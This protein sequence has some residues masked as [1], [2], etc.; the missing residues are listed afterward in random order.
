MIPLQEV[1]VM[2]ALEVLFSQLAGQ[3]LARALGNNRFLD[4]NLLILLCLISIRCIIVCVRIIF[5]RIVGVV[6]L[7]DFCG[8]FMDEVM[9]LVLVVVVVFVMVSV[10]VTPMVVS[11]MALPVLLVVVIVMLLMVH[12]V[13]L[14][15]LFM[16]HGFLYMLFMVH[17]VHQSFLE[18]L[19]SVRLGLLECCLIF[20]LILFGL[21]LRQRHLLGYRDGYNC[22][23]RLFDNLGS[24][25]VLKVLPMY[26]L[27]RH[28]GFFQ[29]RQ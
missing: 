6:H 29:L 13:G 10:M 20:Y 21:F 25:D 16:V 18:V 28:L 9:N 1:S 3:M 5:L 26:W 14:T 23:R 8:D 22:F 4:V 17:V 2:L 19:L 11:V 15:M 27:T 12:L 7:F 24:L